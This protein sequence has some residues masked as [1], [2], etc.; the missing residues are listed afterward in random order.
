MS[1]TS[2]HL[3][4]IMGAIFGWHLLIATPLLYASDEVSIPFFTAHYEL[5]RNDGMKL[6]EV[7]RK[8]T[9]EKNGAMTFESYSKTTGLAALFIKDKITERTT[10]TLNGNTIQPLNYLYD[11]SGGKRSRNARLNF[12][13]TT[14][15]VTNAINNEAWKMKIAAGTQD[16]LSYQLQLML[17]LQA[18]LT[19]FEYPVADGGTLKQ[20]RF[21][22]LGEETLKTPMGEIETVQLK[23]ER[24]ADSKRKTTIW[25]AR[26]LYYLPVK[27]KQGKSDDEF[28]TLVIRKIEG[29][30]NQR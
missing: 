23:R 2:R 10:F 11:R 25:F 9:I 12:D 24:A 20:Y 3:R 18:G 8:T 29:L 27:I 7:K 14:K 5:L 28:V 21:T 19:T 13:W 22:L 6:G 16:K 17:D 4:S 26:S 15:S 30:Q 1:A